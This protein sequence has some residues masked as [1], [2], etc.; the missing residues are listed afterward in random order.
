M[1]EVGG[2]D[3]SRETIQALEEFTGLLTKWNRSINL[4]AKSTIADIW[5]RH[6]VDSAQILTWETQNRQNW[7]DIGSGGGLPGMIVSIILHELDPSAI[8]T[9]V[10]SDQ[11]KA[12]FLRSAATAL[13]LNAKIKAQRVEAL[14]PA[15]ANVLSAR[16][17]TSLNGLFDSGERHLLPDG[18]LL[19]LKGRTYADEI[20]EARKTW[21]FDVVTRPSMTDNEAKMLMIR[22]LERANA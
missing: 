7:L 5:Q 11:R 13:N 12:A 17:L 2:V 1:P 4:V 14:L 22:N 19:L 10:E 16:A 3:V 6:I 8:V 15:N 20:A 21:H 9:L 18:C